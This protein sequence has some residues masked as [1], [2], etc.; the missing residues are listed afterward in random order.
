MVP[1]RATL[2]LTAVLASTSLVAA[3]GP[4]HEPGDEHAQTGLALTFDVLGD[5][6]VAGFAFTATEVDCATGAPVVPANVVTDTEDLEDVY[7]PGTGGEFED[8]P[9][10]G[11]SAH[12][13]SD[14]FFA[15]TPG[16]YDV[17]VQPV[18]ESGEDSAD[19]ASA[20]Q[21]NVEVIDGET[22]EILLISQCVGD[23]S[24]GGLDVIAAL[25]HPPVI[26]D[27]YYDPSKFICGRETTIC[28][29]TTDVDGDPVTVVPSGDG[30]V[31]AIPH[32]EDV[33]RADCFTFTFPGPGSYD[34][35]FTAYDMGYNA[36][37]VLVPIE[38]LLAAQGDPNPSNDSLTVPVHVLPESECI[39]ACGC[40]EG[41]EPTP[42]ESECIRVDTLSPIV[43]EEQVRICPIEPSTAYGWG[44]VFYPDGARDTSIPFFNNRLNDI[45]I[46]GC[47]PEPEYDDGFAS[48]RPLDE[49]V[50]FNLCM[51]VPETG[52]YVLGIA[53]DD[54]VRFSVNGVE[55]F[56][57][58]YGHIFTRWWLRPITLQSGMNIVQIEALNNSDIGAMGADIY[59][60]YSAADTSSDA[61]LAT[62]NYEDNIIWTTEGM[63]GTF[64]I[65]EESGMRCPDDYVMNT[66]DREVTCTR[67]QRVDCQ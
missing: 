8:A 26:D 35:T 63:S 29:S 40:P 55:L 67:I 19:C 4:S 46:W 65:G 60:P 58:A 6:D 45:G 64:P 10:D 13:F 31:S 17:E 44:G 43:F 23:P 34:V 24:T 62:L 14:H 66:C 61:S 11:D 18:T 59:G 50:G 38:D 12:V 32:D 9:F 1:V 56:N 27:L 5:T 33:S 15:L 57:Q 52:E 39:T 53:G 3:C 37:G 48:S 47:W 49:W 36:D 41:F 30:F 7:F 54:A 28:V 21:A 25:N 20:S 16:C 22:T 42:D 51:N 2:A